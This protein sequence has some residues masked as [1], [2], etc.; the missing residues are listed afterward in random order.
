MR[1]LGSGQHWTGTHDSA[2]IVLATGMSKGSASDV[3]RGK[4]TPHVSTWAALTALVE[5][6]G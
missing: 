1:G 3:R 6:R 2:H 5:A 4:W